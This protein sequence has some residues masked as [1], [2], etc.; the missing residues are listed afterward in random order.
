MRV[1]GLAAVIVTGIA[2]SAGQAQATSSFSLSG[3]KMTSAGE[4][5]QISFNNSWG[6]PQLDQTNEMVDLTLHSA[7]GK[8]FAL[9]QVRMNGVGA[10]DVLVAGA[11]LQPGENYW[12]RGRWPASGHVWG[13]QYSRNTG[14]L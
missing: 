6:N 2:A 14:T 7:S 13:N 8:T 4:V 10:I 12:I 3:N 5:A 1:A 9:G 11:G